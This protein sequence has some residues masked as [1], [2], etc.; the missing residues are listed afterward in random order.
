MANDF[1]YLLVLVTLVVVWGKLNWSNYVPA[2]VF[3]VLLGMIVSCIW[4]TIPFHF[5]P[6]FF[7]YMLLPPILLQSA[8]EFKLSLLRK[9]WLPS[10][11]FAIP[12]TLLST[13]VIAGGIY[14]WTDETDLIRIL[15]FASILAPTDTVATLA[16]RGRINYK[17]AVLD[18]LENESIMNDAISVAMV[19]ILMRADRSIASGWLLSEIVFISCVNLTLSVVAG[20]GSSFLMNR[21]PSSDISLHYLISLLVYGL[22]ESVGISGIVSLF[23]YG[24]TLVSPSEFKETV[25]AVASMMESYVYLMLG[26]ALPSFEFSWNS[27]LVLLACLM[28]RIV[29]VFALGAL[30]HCC[31]DRYW[32]VSKLLF[33]SLCGVRGAISYALCLEVGTSFEKSTTFVVVMSTI[34]C[35]GSLQRCMH[36]ILLTI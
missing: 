20:I 30:L 15:I 11:V 24:S 23:V 4:K 9:T 32:S 8:F 2:S 19:H 36:H 31:G 7:M 12:G 29:V 25:V 3:A 33:F 14:V 35:M 34:I 16:L 13:V 28:S 22:C 21:W 17:G 5:A 26:L 1:V 18:V 10:L 27:V 6:E